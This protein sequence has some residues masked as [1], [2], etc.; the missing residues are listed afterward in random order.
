[1]SIDEPQV[2]V[3][4]EVTIDPNATTGSEAKEAETVTGP[5][6]ESSPAT[7]EHVIQEFP[8]TK[9]LK[10]LESVDWAGLQENLS[11][12]SGNIADLNVIAKNYPN[13]DAAGD[14]KHREW[15][16]N[17]TAAQQS[18]NRGNVF[19]NSVTREDSE[20]GQYV[21][22]EG[23][24]LGASRP[25][26]SEGGA[27]LSG[28]RAVL[29][30]AA[31]VGLGSI[32]QIPLW[33]T[34]IWISFKA[35]PESAILELERRIS[36]DKVSLGRATSGMVFSNSGVYTT[37][38]LV[39][40]ALNYVFDTNAQE[41]NPDYLKSIIKITDIPAL[42]WGLALAIYPNG[43]PYAQSCINPA[44]T[45]AHVIKEQLD[46]GKLIWTDRSALT[47]WQRRR[48]ANRKA[49]MSVEDLK[50]Y[51]GEHTHGGD[52]VVELT[53]TVSMRLKV[54]T[55]DEFEASGFAWVDGIVQM[56]EDSFKVP[57]RGEERDAYISSQGRLTTMRQY[58]H[59]VGEVIVPD[60]EISTDRETIDSL[61][62][63]F[64]AEETLRD[65]YITEMGRYIEDSTISLIGLPRHNCP[66]CNYPQM[67][68]ADKKHPFLI[69]VDAA[70]LFF[71]LLSQRINKVLTKSYL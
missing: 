6:D 40:F 42:L 35:P 24:R 54:P 53:D 22:H 11:F 62:D 67:S 12:I 2:P 34:G 27:V 39:N 41:V 21:Q 23:E 38:S 55:L 8:H 66:A 57:L 9:P 10:N 19:A 25:R 46:L 45:C 60:T 51:A 43:Y 5:T 26:F 18:F 56:M 47:E 13:I 71:T 65:A 52:R 32:V 50:R 69:P 68:D 44:T 37:S 29:R 33:H 17:L 59:W 30:V 20:W 49:R 3:D 61:M 4:P 28:E 58:S 15:L 14:V 31:Q 16:T 1:M 48:M 64:S 63:L 70:Q 7:N 36:N